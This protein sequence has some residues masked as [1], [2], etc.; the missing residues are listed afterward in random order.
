MSVEQEPERREQEGDAVDADTAQLVREAQRGDE[1]AMARLLAVLAPYV[2]RLCAP[3]ALSDGEDA[4]QEAL[5]AVFRGLRS[6]RD[7]QAVYGWVR[8]IA[9]REAIRVVRRHGREAPAELADLPAP[10][11]IH[12]TVHVRDVLERLSPEH[13]AILV[14]REVEGLDER[15]AARLLGIS[16][17]TAK[18]R[19]HRARARF[20][21][22]WSA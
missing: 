1:F 17:G 14:L 9:V 3:I 12:A 22:A 11:D 19:L 4:T 7:P 2:G 16:L 8:V 21:E 15:S 6:V 20:K 18:S 5:I 10:G 13:R